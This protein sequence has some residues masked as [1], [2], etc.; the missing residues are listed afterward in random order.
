MPLKV[1]V[2]L[3]KKEGLPNFSSM[4]ANCHVE[5]ELDNG[6][7]CDDL[8]SLHRHIRD[9]YVACAQAVNDEL[10][11]QRSSASISIHSTLADSIIGRVGRAEC[12]TI[13]KPTANNGAADMWFHFQKTFI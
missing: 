12:A 1:C 3:T 9:A 5:V 4:G 7:L 13:V 8:E 10:T 11:R 6:L 2:G